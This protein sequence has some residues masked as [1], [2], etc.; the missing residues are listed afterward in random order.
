VIAGYIKPFLPSYLEIPA[1][2]QIDR[3][4]FIDKEIR[5]GKGRW[6]KKILESLDRFGSLQFHKRMFV[7]EEEQ[8]ELDAASP[9][10]GDI[11]VGID[12]K[13][14]EARR[15]THKRSDEIINKANI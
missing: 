5:K 6:E 9:K 1:I 12:I 11:K 2:S 7:A 15:D 14:I 13:R 4:A 8:F 3:I 10:S